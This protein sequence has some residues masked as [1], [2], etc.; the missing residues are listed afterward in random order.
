MKVFYG[1][2]FTGKTFDEIV[3]ERQELQKKAKY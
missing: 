3:K 2:A 1:M